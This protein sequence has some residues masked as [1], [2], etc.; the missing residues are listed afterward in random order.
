LKRTTYLWG[1]VGMKLYLVQHAEAKKKEED[2]SRPITEKGKMDAE[3]VAKYV[4]KLRL[5]ITQIFHSGKL[6]AKQTAEIFF[7]H[8]KPEDGISEIEGINPLDPPEIAAK[9]LE[10]M[11]KDVMLVGHLPHLSKL[12]S[13]LVI[14]DKNREIIKFRNAGVVCLERD[15]ENKWKILWA[16]TPDII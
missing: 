7:E 14:Q 13:T 4:S 2:P 9:K 10:E 11:D 6:R 15:T 1:V 16:V 3:K 5:D 8:L 12:V